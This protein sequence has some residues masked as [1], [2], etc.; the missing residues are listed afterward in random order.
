MTDMYNTEH[1]SNISKA[2]NKYD[3]TIHFDAV[4]MCGD[5]IGIASGAVEESGEQ[6]IQCV[7]RVR[8]GQAPK[9]RDAQELPP[10]PKIFDQHIVVHNP[11]G[12]PTGAQHQD[13]KDRKTSSRSQQHLP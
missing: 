2:A 12:D 3:T 10:R 11:Q 1:P 4:I 9:K 5:L 8:K 6:K 13:P 7:Q